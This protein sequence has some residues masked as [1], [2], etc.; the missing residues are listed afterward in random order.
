MKVYL[1]TRKLICNSLMHLTKSSTFCV[2]LNLY[3][4]LVL[5]FLIETFPCRFI[6]SSECHKFRQASKVIPETSRNMVGVLLASD[7]SPRTRGSARHNE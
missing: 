6:N 7:L 2:K 4:E 5:N 1:N 3:N